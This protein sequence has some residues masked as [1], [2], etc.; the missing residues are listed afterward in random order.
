VQRFEEVR[1]AGTV[2]AGEE[3][4]AGMERQLELTVGPEIAERDVANDQAVS[5]P[6]LV[7]ELL[8]GQLLLSQ[9]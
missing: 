3:D 2:R 4:D 6:T 7:G 5:L 1:L 9:P 8:I